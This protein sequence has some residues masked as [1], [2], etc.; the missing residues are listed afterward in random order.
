MSTKANFEKLFERQTMPIMSSYE[1]KASRVLVIEPDVSLRNTLRQALVSMGIGG[2]FDAPNHVQ[3]LQKIQERPFTHIIFDAKQSNM[4]SAD[5]LQKALEL[6]TEL[7]AIPTSFEPSVDDVFNLLISGARGYLVK[8]FTTGSVDD[9]VVMASKGEPISEAVLLA[10]DRNEALAALVVTTL[11]KYAH[12]KRQAY[13]FETA[14]RELP[15]RKQ[16]LMRAVD[17]GRT[18][19]R[20]GEAALLHSIM[21]F[22]LERSKGPASRLGRLR[23]RLESKKN[24]KKDG[25]Q[26]H[27]LV[28]ELDFI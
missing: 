22:C 9:A 19:A 25:E 1:R 4:P 6:D 28:E 12:V 16:H 13:H 15:R 3:G 7:V 27:E 5:F 23:K 8:P 24:Q 26:S 17:V 11:D 20:G 18:F 21:D 14:E 2:I 10:K